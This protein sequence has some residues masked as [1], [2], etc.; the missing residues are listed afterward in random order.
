M[1]IADI[2]DSWLIQYLTNEEKLEQASYEMKP[3]FLN[4]LSCARKIMGYTHAAL[5]EEIKKRDLKVCA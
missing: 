4:N 1:K 5:K 3:V 2:P